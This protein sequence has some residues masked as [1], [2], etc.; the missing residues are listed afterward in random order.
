MDRQL[1]Q[2]VVGAAVLVALG[3][4]FIPLILDHNGIET[5]PTDAVDIPPAPSDDFTSRVEPLDEAA[6]AELEQRAAERVELPDGDEASMSEEVTPGDGPAEPGEDI[7]PVPPAPPEPVTSPAPDVPAAPAEPLQPATLA[8]KPVE[9][10]ARSPQRVPSPIP[11]SD[12]DAT[13]PAPPAGGGDPAWTVQLGS[14]GNAEN[15]ARLSDKLRAAGYPGY[16]EKRAE[17]GALVYKV[18]VGPQGSRAEAEQV[19]ARLTAQFEL[20]GLLLHYP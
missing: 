4:I 9:V 6:I 8:P 2:R 13:R 16:V 12:D 10:P 15:A 7:E 14:F 18:R 5:R 17:A 11:A 19:R 3:V 20:K 1:K